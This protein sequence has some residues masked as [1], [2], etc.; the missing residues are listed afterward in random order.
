METWS[1]DVLPYL[2]KED[3]SFINLLQYW[4]FKKWRRKF[5]DLA[6]T[7]SARAYVMNEFT[8]EDTKKICLKTGKRFL[9]KTVT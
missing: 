9:T 6:E 1:Q 3:Y 2:T 8:G 4:F 5:A 7:S